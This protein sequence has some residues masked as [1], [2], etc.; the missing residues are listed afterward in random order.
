M[1]T[2]LNVSAAAD[3]V[4]RFAVI[5]H[6]VSH[7]RSPAIHQMFGQQTGI[8]L[9]YDRLEAPLDGFEQVVETFFAQGGQGLNVTVPFKRQA[10]NLSKQQLSARAKSAL[11]VNT[12][13]MQDGALHGCNTDGVGLVQDL[14]RLSVPLSQ[15]RILMI[16]AGGAARGVM[17][18]LL[19]S[20][21][22]HLRVVNR[23]VQRA[24]ELVAEW[25]SK[26]AYGATEISAASLQDAQIAGGWDLVIN[27]SAS[28]LGDAPPDVPSGLYARNALAYD[29]MYGAQPSPFMRQASQDGA[30]RTSDGL[31]MLV[32]QAAESFFLWHGVR[33]EVSPV[34]HQIRQELTNTL[35]SHSVGMTL[36]S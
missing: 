8:A 9:Q 14:N 4:A 36:T 18:P 1:T 21:C 27:A 2:E 20:G 25:R 33:P 19:E 10:W 31:G 26:R 30:A 22:L 6:P 13:W 11:A 28:S 3:Q 12:L 29:M 17:G 35:P 7:S 34:L 5:G 16:G 15:S 32:S 23:S 24:H